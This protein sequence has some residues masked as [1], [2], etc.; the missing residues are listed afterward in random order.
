MNEQLQA[1]LARV[2]AAVDAQPALTRVRPSGFPERAEFRFGECGWCVRVNVRN[3]LAR[4][5][6]S[7]AFFD[8]MGEGETPDLAVASF[9]ERLPYVVQV[10][11][12]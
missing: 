5:R 11:S 2:E 7:R 8:A 1:L 9:M 12:R 6:G 4:G 10:T 3:V